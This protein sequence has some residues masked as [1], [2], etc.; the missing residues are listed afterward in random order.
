MMH[1]RFRFYDNRFLHNKA[2]YIGQCL[3][4]TLVA[5][6][7][8]MC[9][10]LIANEL[11]IASIAST[12]F[13]VF[14]QPQGGLSKARYI[15]GGYVVGFIIGGLSHYLQV[16]IKLI[17]KWPIDDAIF[18]ACAVGLCIFFMV[19][20]DLEHPPAAAVALAL[21]INPWTPWTVIVTLIAISILL[22]AKHI[23][24]RQLINLY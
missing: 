19:V 10:K 22:L 9:I 21:V 8:L 12:I 14:A 7:L 11:V 17:Q 15:L 6:F 1:K 16:Y 20:F 18:G 24:K 2:R 4:A 13:M 5:F 23:F 3:M